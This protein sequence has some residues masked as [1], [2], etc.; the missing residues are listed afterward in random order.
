MAAADFPKL[1]RAAAIQTRDTARVA[2]TR[3]C[4][5]DLIHTDRPSQCRHLPLADVPDDRRASPARA[6]RVENQ[7]LTSGTGPSVL[8]SRSHS[9]SVACGPVTNVP[10]TFVPYQPGL[11]PRR[12]A[13]VASTR[14]E[15]R[16]V[17]GEFPYL[18]D[19]HFG[20][21]LAFEARS[22]RRRWH[23]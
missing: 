16:F 18:R 5:R 3:S 2:A 21:V 17:I 11:T 12:P 22:N 4:A 6:S 14:R 8:I 9:S 7:I 13:S 19:R 10:L 15:E 23:C 20:S 1:A